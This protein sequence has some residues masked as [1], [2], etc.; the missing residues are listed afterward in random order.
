MAVV[1]GG[2]KR[3]FKS[4]ALYR[5]HLKAQASAL[6]P[7]RGS[8]QA[9]VYYGSKCDKSDSERRPRKGGKVQPLTKLTNEARAAR[10]REREQVD[11]DMIQVM[12]APVFAPL[13]E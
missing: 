1:R 3:A 10:T 4:N 2:A 8:M 5:A 11:I 9:G 6:D 13:G 7:T 12:T